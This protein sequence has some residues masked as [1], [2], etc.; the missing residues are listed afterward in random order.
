L[1]SIINA[2]VYPLP[3]FRIFLWLFI[4]PLLNG[5]QN[6]LM[7]PA[8]NPALLPRGA[9]ILDGASLARSCPVTMQE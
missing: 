9:L 2:C 1:N 3:C 6:L 4:E 5:V 8:R 7:F